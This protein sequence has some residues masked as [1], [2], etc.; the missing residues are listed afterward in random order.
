MKG[1]E[2]REIQVAAKNR[3]KWRQTA[4]HTNTAVAPS[5]GSG[6]DG[7]WKRDLP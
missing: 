4:R 2:F 3:Q 7:R 6:V 5:H 1:N